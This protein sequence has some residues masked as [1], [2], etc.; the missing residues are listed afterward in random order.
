M[1]ITILERCHHDPSLGHKSLVRW[2]MLI[3]IVDLVEEEGQSVGATNGL[4]VYADF[5]FLGATVI[6]RVLCSSVLELGE[7]EVEMVKH[8]LVVLEVEF[9]A[10]WHVA[11]KLQSF[12]GYYQALVR[13]QGE[14]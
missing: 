7:L 10:Q 11:V 9:Q 12:E 1:P 4:L 5:L 3:R 14:L 2:D 8:M 13:S 6:I